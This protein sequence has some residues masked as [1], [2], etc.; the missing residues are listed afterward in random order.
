MTSDF[1]P[2]DGGCECG[3]VRYRLTAAPRTVHV[4]HCRQCQ[5]LSGSAFSINAE[6]RADD[7]EMI[8]EAEPELLV[9]ASEATPKGRMWWC[10]KCA[11]K[12]YADHYLADENTRYLRVGTLDTG[13]A[14]PPRAHFFTRSKHPWIVLPPELPA[15][16]TFPNAKDADPA[17]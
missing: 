11:T 15:Y 13:E 5:R 1:R 14:L 7:L 17:G 8:G 4:C 6:I 16:T 3:R 10:P 12:L 9:V 2:L